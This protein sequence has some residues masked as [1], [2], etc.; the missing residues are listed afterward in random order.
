M[1][2][3]DLQSI[4]KSLDSEISLKSIS[5]LNQSLTVKTQKT[6]NK[7]LLIL[8]TDILACV[9]LMIFLTITAFN[10]QGDI[11]YLANNSL[12]FIITAVSLATSLFTLNKLQNNKYNLPLK[13]WLEQRIK[14]LSGWLLGKYSKLYILMIPLLLV[15]INL[16]IHVYYESKPFIEVM[17]NQESI[18]GLLFG[19]LIGILVAFYA[20]GKI[21]KYQLKNLEILKDLYARLCDVC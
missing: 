19:L 10:R 20:I 1:E 3:K 6:I 5:E 12:L 7:Y 21:R 17:K 9:G 8:S 15:L 2:T 18:Y 13:E 11:L 14:M 4:W 16:S